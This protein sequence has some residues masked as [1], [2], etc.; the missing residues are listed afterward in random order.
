MDKVQG[1][2][3]QK[4]LWL[5]EY[6]EHLPLIEAATLQLNGLD[7]VETHHKIKGEAFIT[8][9]GYQGSVLVKIG[10]K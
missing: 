5:Q 1:N 7:I 3:L 10:S 4:E 6:Q 2:I 8:V 9:Q